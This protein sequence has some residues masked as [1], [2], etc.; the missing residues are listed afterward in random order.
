MKK[1]ESK[2]IKIVEGALREAF[3]ALQGLDQKEGSQVIG[4]GKA[5]G[6]LD[7][8]IEIQTDILLGQAIA[9]FLKEQKISCQ[10]QIEG[11]EE[12]LLGSSPAEY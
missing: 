6:D 4:S 1:I 2:I 5:F 3:V 12:A 8:D 9:D 11:Q 10:L 7:K